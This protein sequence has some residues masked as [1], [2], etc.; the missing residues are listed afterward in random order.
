MYRKTSKISSRAYI[1]IRP[2]WTNILKQGDIF[3]RAYSVRMKRN[4]KLNKREKSWEDF[5]IL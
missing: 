4:N 2:Y 5:K 3:G 1:F